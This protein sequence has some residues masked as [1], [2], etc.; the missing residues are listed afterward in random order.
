MVLKHIRDTSGQVHFFL[1]NREAGN[2]PY[3]AYTAYRDQVE[4]VEREDDHGP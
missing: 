4:E 3:A 2:P 1:N